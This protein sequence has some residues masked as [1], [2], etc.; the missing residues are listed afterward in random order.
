VVFASANIDVYAETKASK[1]D[2]EIVRLCF[3][4]FEVNENRIVTSH[5]RFQNS[6]I[7]TTYYRNAG[8][9]PFA[10]IQN[11]S[12][13]VNALSIP[14]SRIKALSLCPFSRGKRIF[15]AESIPIIDMKGD[16][17][18]LTPEPWGI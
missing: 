8:I 18:E 5:R 17:H 12:R 7:F 15:P 3:G 13:C 9:S 11:K 6:R 2:I 14:V 1:I 4:R 10:P 16:R